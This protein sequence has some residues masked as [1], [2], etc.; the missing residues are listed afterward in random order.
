MGARSDGKSL[1]DPEKKCIIE[2]T[3]SVAPYPHIQQIFEEEGIDFEEPC[4]IRREINPQGKSRT[5]VN[6]SPVN[7][8]SLKKI[9][10]ELVDIHSQQDTWWLANTDFTL[11]LVDS[12][13]QNQALK[14]AYQTSYRIYNQATK[15]L[16]SLQ[17]KA[18]EGTQGLDFLQFQFQN[19]LLDAC[20]DPRFRAMLCMI[21]SEA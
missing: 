15:N 13:A 16:Q 18:A 10:Q 8:D 1:F 17:K 7:L 4:I 11:E 2:G 12:F 3:F 6:D 14:L 5:F 21:G 19:A 9:G 20:R